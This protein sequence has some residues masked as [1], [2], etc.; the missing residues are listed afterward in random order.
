MS[1]EITRVELPVGNYRLSRERDGAGDSGLFLE[2]FDW[3]NPT[4][5]HEKRVIEVGKGVRCGSLY[6]RTMQEQD[7]WL[8]TAVKEILEVSDDG[9]MVKFLTESRNN[10][11]Y[12]VT[13]T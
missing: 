7:W 2:A 13:V 3:D 8:T 6:T 1:K 12:I 10:S 5:D 9:K 11:T 4:A